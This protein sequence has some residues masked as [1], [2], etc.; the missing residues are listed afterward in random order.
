MCLFLQNIPIHFSRH[1][2]P[3]S[4]PR[5][6]TN[7]AR[8]PRGGQGSPE[9][10]PEADELLPRPV[11]QLSNGGAPKL[12]KREVP[13]DAPLHP[14]YRQSSAESDDRPSKRTKYSH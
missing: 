10:S 14:G 5:L 7:I 8:S 1:T 12:E 2:S 11:S 13:H 4:C 9:I 3:H 6:K